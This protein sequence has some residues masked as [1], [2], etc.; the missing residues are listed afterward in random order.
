MKGDAVYAAFY[1]DKNSKFDIKILVNI[2]NCFYIMADNQ[3]MS[4]I[5]ILDLFV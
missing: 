3:Y 5:K 1:F 4:E 2:G